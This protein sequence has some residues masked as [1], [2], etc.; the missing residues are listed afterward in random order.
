M[1]RFPLF[2]FYD[3]EILVVLAERDKR[4]WKEK[5]LS[6]SPFRYTFLC[7]S[8]CKDRSQSDLGK[9]LV[10]ILFAPVFAIPFVNAFCKIYMFGLDV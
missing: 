1:M 10:N 4:I 3:G 9:T 5:T 6:P 7:I 8:C 2:I